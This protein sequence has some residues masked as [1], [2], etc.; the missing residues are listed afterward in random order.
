MSENL[1]WV[2]SGEGAEFKK[3]Q[4][5]EDDFNRRFRS[6]K[7]AEQ[8]PLQTEYEERALT[9]S[10]EPGGAF[11]EDY[12]GFEVLGQVEGMTPEKLKAM[13][14]EQILEIKGIGKKTLEE[15]RAIK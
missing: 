8:P 4:M 14:D 15:I 11:P 5:T 3:E 7:A 9:G 12:P 1:I 10:G 2:T 13:T 6:G